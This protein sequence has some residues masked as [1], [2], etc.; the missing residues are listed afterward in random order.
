[1][2]VK[3]VILYRDNPVSQPR[4][5]S[6]RFANLDGL[7]NLGP[8]GL[9]VAKR[10]LEDAARRAKDFVHKSFDWQQQFFDGEREERLS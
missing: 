6:L 1:M 8:Y 9:D 3:P 7:G 5:L 4:V 10:R 2:L